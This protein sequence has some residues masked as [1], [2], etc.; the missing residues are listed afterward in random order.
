MSDESCACLYGGYGNDDSDG[1]QCRT[2]LVA[3]IEHKCIECAKSIVK[4]EMYVR[5]AGKDGGRVFSN[6]TCAICEEIREALYCDG[7]YFG[8]MWQDIEEQL[9]PHFTVACVDK[10]STVAAKECLSKRYQEWVLTF[11]G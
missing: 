4:G 3:R 10:L 1:F 6:K 8:Q 7:Y 2:R 11:N 9:F 5:F